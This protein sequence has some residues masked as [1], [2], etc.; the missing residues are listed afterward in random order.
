[1]HKR[2][3]VLAAAVLLSPSAFAADWT[4]WYV[5]ADVGHARGDSRARVAL[6]DSWLSLWGDTRAGAAVKGRF[7]LRGVRFSYPDAHA[8]ALDGVSLVVRPGEKVA[9]I[10]RVGCGKSTLL[11][12]LV[13]LCDFGVL[14][15]V[16]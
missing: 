14:L 16:P 10:G 1:M 13:R 8:P 12:L 2:L 7:D 11:R 9:V 6:G 4:G 5:G 15:A 3:C